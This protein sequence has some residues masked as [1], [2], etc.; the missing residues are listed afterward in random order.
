MRSAIGNPAAGDSGSYNALVY[1]FFY[2]AYNTKM[3]SE[4][5]ELVDLADLK[6]LPAWVKEPAPE[7]YR[8]YEPEPEERPEHRRRRERPPSRER[9]PRRERRPQDRHRPARRD[10]SRPPRE[11]DRVDRRLPPKPP[12]RPLEIEIR[13]LPQPR[14]VEAV[15]AQIKAD[16]LA[17]SLFSLARMF[18]QKPERYD[19]RL[20]AKPESPFYRLG[21]NGAVSA[22]RQLLENNA[23]R[24][25][26]N[27]FYKIDMTQSDP[28]KG[29]FTSV[30]RD[31][32]SGTLLGPT[33]Y[34]TYQ[35][36][37]RTLYEQRFSRRMSFADYQRQIEIVTDPAL[38]EKWKEEA[39]TVTT[40]TTLREETPVTFNNA[41]EAEKHFRQEYLAGLIRTI[42]DALIDGVASRTLADRILRRRI[43]DAWSAEMRSPS[44]MM[45]ELAGRLRET[46]LHVFRHRRGMLF[47]GP[48]RPHPLGYEETSVSPQVKAIL[49][50]I[51]ATPQ[52]NRKDL[53]DKLVVDLP[54]EELES[55]KLSLASDLHWLIGEGYV[56]EFNDGSLD[57]PRVKAPSAK[58][59]TPEKTQAPIPNTDAADAGAAAVV[60]TAEPREQG[61]AA[62]DAP[63]IEEMQIGGS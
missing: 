16:A 4:T 58:Q 45:Q 23:F 52:T 47:I 32:L 30:A 39:R 51:A 24:F 3:P 6:L 46:G 48:I 42:E 27:E 49:E 53:A 5:A 22:D 61:S 57:L 19:V 9:T 35:P 26:Q 10:K 62:E 55:R 15:A 59:Q 7:P 41:A 17:Y 11:R 18:L 1:L 50:T 2:L 12:A 34:H 14:V 28:I 13:F 8:Q 33:N 40:F 56:I 38:V 43:E 29:N 31:P 21:D 60:S 20:V 25:A 37:L 63:A 54:A 44:K 36:R